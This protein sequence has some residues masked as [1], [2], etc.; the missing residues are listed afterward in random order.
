MEH[1][2]DFDQVSL[3]ELEIG[4]KVQDLSFLAATTWANNPGFFLQ[5]VD[6]SASGLLC[7]ISRAMSV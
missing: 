3:I 6:L 7:K 4:N 2:Y 1:N 5:P